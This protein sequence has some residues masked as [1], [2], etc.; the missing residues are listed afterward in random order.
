MLAEQGHTEPEG[1]RVPSIR[2]FPVSSEPPAQ[3][4]IAVVCQQSF[5][6]VVLSNT[7]QGF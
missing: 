4:L 3:V 5:L 6:P 7:Y 1:S 2:V